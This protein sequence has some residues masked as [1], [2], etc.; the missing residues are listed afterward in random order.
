MELCDLRF[1]IHSGLIHS[2]LI[3]AWFSHFFLNGGFRLL[4]YVT[5]KSQMWY[6]IIS[7]QQSKTESEIIR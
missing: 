3:S 6:R 1:D 5:C 7:H 4:V 2:G